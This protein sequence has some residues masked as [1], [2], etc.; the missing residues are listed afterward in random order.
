MDLMSEYSKF[1]EQIDQCEDIELLK[2]YQKDTATKALRDEFWKQRKLYLGQGTPLEKQRAQVKL[3]WIQQFFGCRIPLRRT[4]SR[5]SAPEGLFGIFISP[6]AFVGSDC[7]ICQHVTIA[8]ET[9]ADA[10][11]HGFPTIGRNVYIGPG[12]KIIGNVHIGDHVRIEANCCVTQDV[13]PYSIVKAGT[14]EILSRSQ[15][16]TPTYVTPDAYITKLF[17]TVYYDYK[18]HFGDPELTVTQ[19]VAA[20]LDEI[21]ELYKRRTLWFRWKKQS[22][23]THYLLHHPKAEFLTRITNGE[24]Y[25]VRKA[26][27]LI[28]GFSLSTDS[29]NWQDDSAN[30]WYLCRV[31]SL[32]GY[33]NIGEYITAQAKHLAVEAGVAYLRL[34]CL[35]SNTRLNQ[36]WED[37]G[38]RFVREATAD[39]HCSLRECALISEP[40]TDAEEPLPKASE[41][42]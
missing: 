41:E 32:P 10:S 12:A 39:Y 9:A 4:V 29:E 36:I 17:G 31:V 25:I 35:H 30:A 28:A 18:E 7:V 15:A 11:N 6:L 21:W 13:P 16:D 27:Q 40:E 33:K 5:F 20:D 8:A 14:P 37:L 34:E 42:A 1:S 24:Y 23:W 26:D 2:A 3:Q 38:F 19:A 22:Q